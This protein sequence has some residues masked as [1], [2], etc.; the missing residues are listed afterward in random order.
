MH[1]TVELKFGIMQEFTFQV[2]FKSIG[3][4]H[5]ET[6]NLNGVAK[7]EIVGDVKEI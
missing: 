4:N 1:K 3:L 7:V 6:T 2:C 5:Q